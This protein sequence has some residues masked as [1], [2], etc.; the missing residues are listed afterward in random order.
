MSFATQHKNLI[1]GTFDR[2]TA[3]LALLIIGL[4]CAQTGWAESEQ[5][6]TLPSNTRFYVPR[7]LPGSMQQVQDLLRDGDAK[8]ALLIAALEFSPRAVWLYGST[9]SVVGELVEKTLNEA[10]EQEAVPVFSLRAIPGV[11][12]SGYSGTSAQNIAFYEGWIDGIAKAIGE[13]KAVVLLEPDSLVWLPSECGYNPAVVDI[14]QADA[15]RYTEIRYAVA[16]LEARPRTIV[17]LDAGYS[18][19]QAVGT[20]TA[21]LVNADV[22]QA[23]GFFSNESG[24]VLTDYETKFDTWISECIAF[25]N[26]PDDGGW[27]LGHFELCANQ[28]YSPLGTVDPNN[29]ATWIYT[30]EWYQQNLG[31][32]V[33][34]THFVVD[35]SMNGQGPPSANKYANPPFDQPASIVQSLNNGLWCNAPGTGVGLRPTANTGVSLLDAYMWIKL[36]GVSNGTCTAQDGVRAWDYSVYTQPGW[37]TDAAEQATFDPLWGVVA[38]APNAWFPKFALEQ[39]RRANPRLLPQRNGGEDNR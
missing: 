32:A 18:H 30:D 24:F 28:Y 7:P 1:C 35:T 38:P 22:S 37:P 13:R 39:A 12:C 20:M 33:P 5:D 8:D 3:A 6:K 21:R 34:A 14:A 31:N 11:D 16:K 9:P 17:Y 2:L 29:I 25:G 27:R 36:P 23:Q 4:F 19:W 10:E 26:N 15:D